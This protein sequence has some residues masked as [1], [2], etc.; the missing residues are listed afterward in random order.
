MFPFLSASTC[1][2]NAALLCSN[3][4]LFIDFFWVLIGQSD[5]D[6]KT[7][8]N[9]VRKRICPTVALSLWGVPDFTL[10]WK[11]H[12]RQSGSLETPFVRTIYH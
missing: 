9:H 11:T 4:L 6:Q 12:D 5:A 7:D 10:L 1:A 3:S 8:V 2:F